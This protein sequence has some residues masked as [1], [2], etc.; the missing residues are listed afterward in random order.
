MSRLDELIAELCPD[1]VEYVP[2]RCCLHKVEKI[3]W[4]TKPEGDYQYIDLTSVDR[5][6]HLIS[7]TQ[8]INYSNAPSRAQ[9]IVKTGDILLGTTRPMLKRYCM[10]PESYSGQICS[11]G[12][13]VLRANKEIVLSRWLYH[14]ISSS[15]FFNHVEIY[16]RGA[17]YPAISDTDVKLYEIPLPPLEV[18]REIVRILDAYSDWVAELTDRL[19]AELDTRKKQYEYY[20]DDLLTFTENHPFAELCPDGVEYKTLGEVA[21]CCAGAT[22]K[23]GVAK[24][25]ENGTIPWM[26]SGEVNKGI[27]FD[28]DVKITE[29]AYESCSTKLVPANTVVVALAGQGKTRGKVA[30]TRIELCTNQSLCSIIPHPIL[31]SDYLYFYLDSQYRQLRAI[32]TGDGSRGG[33]NLKMIRK[34][35]IP[36]PPLE[37]QR[38]IV[39]IL[40]AYSEKVAELTDRLAAELD[41]RKKQYEHY[42]DQLLTFEK[43]NA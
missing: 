22:P 20:R 25:W 33:L 16:Q 28:T 11:T 39:R 24:Y 31:D 42:R 26:S 6:T 19:A 7:E 13:C 34:Y 2:L 38:E 18:Q 17:S 27:I 12:F 4:K 23:T 35:K 29:L 3:K 32:S 37:V 9:Q 30:R 14:Y 41:A 10:I 21:K 8:T 5:D 1:G 40:D 43:K 36:L 15:D